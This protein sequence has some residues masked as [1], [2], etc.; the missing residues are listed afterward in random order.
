MF[1]EFQNFLTIEAIYL[2]SNFAVMPF[3]LMLVFIPSFRVTK[4]LVYSI[5]LPLILGSLYGYI[6]YQGFLLNNSFLE[7]F[8]I[9]LGL[10]NL[11]TIFSNDIFLTFFWIHFLSLNLFLGTWTANDGVK[12]SIPKKLVFLPLLLIYF[13]GPIGLILYWI[14][15]IFYAKKIGLHD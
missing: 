6:I 12:Y 14:I 5:I 1:T 3:W 13:T 2:Y 7:I 11:Y 4:I 9:Y 15:R 10:E 8:E